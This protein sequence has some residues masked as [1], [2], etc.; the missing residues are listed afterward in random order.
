MIY[1]PALTESGFVWADVTSFESEA[2]ESK[3]E[4]TECQEAAEKVQQSGVEERKANLSDNK[5]RQL[6]KRSYD[7]I[8]RSYESMFA[9][10]WDLK[11]INNKSH[12]PGKIISASSCLHFQALIRF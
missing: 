10:D 2:K 9:F 12:P 5:N 8:C 6:G 11:D 7:E 3:L 4:N 1:L